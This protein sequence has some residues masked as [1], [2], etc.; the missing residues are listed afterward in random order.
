MEEKMLL[1]KT[2]LVTSIACLFVLTGCQKRIQPGQLSAIRIGMS[3][4]EV[5]SN[6]GEPEVQRGSMVN[7]FNQEIDVYEYQVDR[8]PTDQQYAACTLLCICT[9]G[10]ALPLFFFLPSF[11]DPYWMCFCDDKLRMW[12][13]AGDWETSQHNIQEIRF[14]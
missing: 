4:N 10:I 1:N 12:C 9:L 14:R 7:N 6:L 11:S 3:K 2:L 8:G 13:K 5:I